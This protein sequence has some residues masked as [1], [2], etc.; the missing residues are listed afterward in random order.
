MDI[1]EAFHQV[2]KQF[3]YWK[4]CFETWTY[5]TLFEFVLIGTA[6]IGYRRIDTNVVAEQYA[7]GSI[8]FKGSFMR[9]P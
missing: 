9:S 1:G 5:L 2:T 8:P 7:T 3:I 4:C 6:T